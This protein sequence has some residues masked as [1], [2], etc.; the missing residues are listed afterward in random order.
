M[1]PTQKQSPFRS[2]GYLIPLLKL[3]ALFPSSSSP[4]FLPLPLNCSQDPG[5]NP[6]ATVN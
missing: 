3:P 2:P 6:D 4:L 1:I 5:L